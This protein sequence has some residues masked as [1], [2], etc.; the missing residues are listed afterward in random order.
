MNLQPWLAQ[1]EYS[2]DGNMVVIFTSLIL[3]CFLSGL[4]LFF[5]QMMAAISTFTTMADQVVP[6]I[7]YVYLNLGVVASMG[8]SVF[9]MSVWMVLNREDNPVSTGVTLVLAIMFDIQAL[10]AL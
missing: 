6:D 4:F 8:L 9:F 2:A 3:T 10:M 1:D 5:P 7:F